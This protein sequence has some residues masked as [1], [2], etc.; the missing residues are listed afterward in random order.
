MTMHSGISVGGPL[1]R[2]GD[3]LTESLA[4]LWWR[5]SA[6]WRLSE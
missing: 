2:L 5:K 6:T 3:A 4:D 1:H